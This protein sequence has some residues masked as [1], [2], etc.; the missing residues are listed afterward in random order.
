MRKKTISTETTITNTGE[1]MKKNILM[2]EELFVKVYLNNQLSR[3]TNHDFLLQIL[4]LMDYDN[5][6]NLNPRK[7]DRIAEVIGL[8]QSSINKLLKQLIDKNLA[9][10]LYPG[11]YLINPYIFSKRDFKKTVV[12]RQFYDTELDRVKKSKRSGL[13]KVEDID[14]TVTDIRTGDLDLSTNLNK[15]D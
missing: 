10:R 1:E 7:K 2:T 14:Q 5:V 13:A 8:R 9:V 12:I 11:E 4:S 15:D 3:F 6:V